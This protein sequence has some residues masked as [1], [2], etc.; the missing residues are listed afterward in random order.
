MP[1]AQETVG[2]P[3]TG[4]PYVRFD[5]GVLSAARLNMVCGSRVRRNIRC[6]LSGN[7]STLL[8]CG[9]VAVKKI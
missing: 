2:E 5:E 4:N 1:F 3:Y 9:S 8:Y 6:L 7:I